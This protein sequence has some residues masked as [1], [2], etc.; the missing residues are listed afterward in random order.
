MAKYEDYVKGDD[1]LQSEIEDASQ[2]STDRAEADNQPDMPERFQGKSAE[3]IAQSF[4]ELEAMSSRQANDLGTMRKTVDQ[5]LELQS[6]STPE[7]TPVEPISI[8]D[9]YDNPTEAITKVAEQAVGSKI[10]ALEAELAQARYNNELAGLDAKYQGWRADAQ[11]PEFVQ[12][13]Q[14]QAYRT[15]MA[16][17]ADRGDITAADSLLEMWYDHKNVDTAAA[18]AEN[19]QALQHAQLESGGPTAVESEVTFSRAELLNQRILA[20]RGDQDAVTYMSKN[21]AA[22]AKAY[23]EGRITD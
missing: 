7:P 11:S 19:A 1:A 10:E 22:I 4:V 17:E 14:S 18:E 20:K 9:V 23:E 16:V 21:S 5:L 3:E 13:T 6:H 15:R 2:A 8:D 12:W